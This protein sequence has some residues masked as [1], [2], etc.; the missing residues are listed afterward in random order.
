ME[1]G[2]ASMLR[3]AMREIASEYEDIGELSPEELEE[4]EALNKEAAQLE[5][6]GRLLKA[7]GEIFWA[8]LE[9]RFNKIGKAL[10]IDNGHLYVRKEKTIAE[11]QQ[12][13]E[14]ITEH[15]PSDI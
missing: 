15:D 1:N 7:K 5:S 6:E 10:K 11:L 2:F 14:E 3:E 13:Q 9:K 4:W 12:I 8:N